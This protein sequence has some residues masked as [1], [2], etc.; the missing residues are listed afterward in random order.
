MSDE[1]SEFPEDI[2]PP[3]L[4]E[5]E[6]EFPDEVPIPAGKGGR[7][8]VKSIRGGRG[9]VG[10]TIWESYNKEGRVQY[11]AQP[12]A[13]YFYKPKNKWLYKKTFYLVELEGLPEAIEAAL[14]WMR[15]RN[16]Q[17]KAR[18]ELK[19]ITSLF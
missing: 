11:N 3:P 9:N 19:E 12:F 6:A 16:E 10:V 18:G 1:D 7:R 17:I 14:R 13:Q 2:P 4:E 15:E 8:P 5:W